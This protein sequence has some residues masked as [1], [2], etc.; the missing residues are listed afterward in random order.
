L[1]LVSAGL[2]E[3]V[4]ALRERV[5]PQ[6]IQQHV[7]DAINLHGTRTI[8]AIAPHVR[9]MHLRRFDDRLAA[10][11]DGLDIA[12]AHAAAPCKAALDV[13][14]ASS[15]FVATVRA[16]ETRQ[17][18]WLGQLIAA[19]AAEPAFF[20]GLKSAFGWLGPGALRGVVNNLL[21]SPDATARAVAISA[22]A[23]HRL[24]PGPVAVSATKDESPLVRARALR[25]AGELGK[26]EL[27]SALAVQIDDEDAACGF[28]AAW[29]AVVLGDRERALDALI[30]LAETPGAFAHRA[31][32]LAMLALSA[33]DAHA[34][35]KHLPRDNPGKRRL[36]QGAGLIGDPAYVPWLIEQ[37]S[38]DK[39]ARIAGGAFS[40]ISG[41]DLALLDL[42][43][44]PPADFEAG[45][46]DDPN[47]P[48]VEMDA[49]DGLP[50][51]DPVRVLAWWSR[52]SVAFSTGARYFAGAALTFESCTHVL[53]TGYQRQRMTAALHRCLLAPGTPL[54]EWRA[55]AWRQQREL[56][57][58]AGA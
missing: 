28:W 40:D 53:R 54:F 45:P 51:P 56:A 8:L 41:A 22:C 36:I 55:P 23:L 20:P 2:R 19:S 34:F 1:S 35:L 10:H 6:V 18:E 29:A 43:R 24:D 25:A 14:H 30:T 38:D 49:D 52:N 7:E 26:R 44:K 58:L 13:P 3:E 33:P 39:V 21:R 46:N 47:D 57:K 50:W 37:M 4:A 32:H 16:L 9:L 15:M 27:V 48:D 42:E 11:L 5:V 12:G 17:E 31:F